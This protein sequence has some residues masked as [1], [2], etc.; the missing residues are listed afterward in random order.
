MTADLRPHTFDGIQEFD[1]RLPNWWLWTFYLAC[2]FSV[3][4]WIHFQTLGTGNQPMDDY[5]DEQAAAA[6][7]MEA[8]LKENP[9]TT[10]VLLELAAN[11]VFVTQGKELFEQPQKCAQCHRVDG[12]AGL[13]DGIAA[14]GANL[15]D[16]YWI[17]GNE[18]MDIYTTILKGRGPDAELGSNGGMLAHE[19]EGLGFVQKVTAFVLSIK[20]TN[21]AGGKNPETYAKK[22]Q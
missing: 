17:Y 6:A 3:F 7:A 11:P 18:P 16:G 4:Y 8:R 12:G 15:T 22:T 9:I 13:L 10:E 2:I 1:N 14:T 20:N 19:A 5:L 21:V